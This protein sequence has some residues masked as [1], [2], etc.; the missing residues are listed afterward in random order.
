MEQ[1]QSQLWMTTQL[2]QKFKD[3]LDN[4]KTENRAMK[5]QFSDLEKAMKEQGLSQ[6]NNL[7]EYLEDY[8]QKQEHPN[9]GSIEQ[10]DGSSV[11]MKPKLKRDSMGDPTNLNEAIARHL[12]VDIVRWMVNGE[13]KSRPPSNRYSDVMRHMVRDVTT[14][15][16]NAFL[17]MLKSLSLDE[18]N[19]YETLTA[20]ADVLYDDERT[21]WGRIVVLYGFGGYIAKNTP[22]ADDTFSTMI[23]DFLGFY[24]STKLLPW[25]EA[26]GG[27]VSVLDLFFGKSLFFQGCVC[28]EI[29]PWLLFEQYTT[30]GSLEVFAH[31]GNLE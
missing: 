16:H 25:I 1:L 13:E 12:A 14:V 15:H 4:L 6:Q 10:P 21:N 20:V 9:R 19:G 28:F 8:I 11:D 27:W 29:M 17:H 24:V 2:V 3:E 18:I 22:G 7:K 31:N 23:G 30:Y 26:A 5:N